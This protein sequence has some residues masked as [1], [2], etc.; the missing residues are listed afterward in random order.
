MKAL[1][2]IGHRFHEIY[3]NCTIEYEYLQDYYETLAKRL[4]EESNKL[5]LFFSSNVQE[6]SVVLPYSLELFSQS[7]ALDLSETYE[8]MI[9]NFT[10]MNSDSN[11]PAEIYAIPTGGELRGMFVNVT[12]LKSLN[13]S[14]PTNQ[15]ELLNACKVLSENG[16]VPLHGNPGSFGQQLLYPYVC[17]LIANSDDYQTKYQQLNS[18]EAGVSAFFEEP[19]SLMYQLIE[20]KYYNYKYVENELAMFIDSSNEGIAR[21]FLSIGMN[22]SGEYYKKDDLGQVAFMPAP[23]TT[24]GTIAKTKEDYHSNIE[25]TFILSPVAEEGGFA[26]MSPAQGLVINK[27]SDQLDWALEFMNFFFTSQNNKAYAEEFGIIPNT[28]DALSYIENKF[29]IK[30]NQISQLGQMTFDYGFYGI[31]T[32]SL[33]EVSKAN[34]PKYMKDETTLYDFSYY[35]D[36][37]ETRFEEQR[38]GTD[39]LEDD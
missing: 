22:E 1:E 9:K 2:D 39:I 21:D 24:S 27:N 33:V 4:P 18:C 29:D 20:N 32:K 38:T 17:N 26:Y 10:Y 14:V 19:M 13:L 7:E 11:A 35:M 37:L 34:N 8:G 15:Q 25:Y 12:L 5:D 3:P 23:M 16:Y 31:I 36:R 30:E 6:G 28:S